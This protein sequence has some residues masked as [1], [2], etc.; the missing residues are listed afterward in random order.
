MERAPD[1]PRRLDEAAIERLV[2]E[3]DH[4]DAAFVQ[5]PY[6]VYARLREQG[7]VVHSEHYGGFYVPTR[8]ADIRAIWRDYARF[9]VQPSVN[10]PS[11]FGNSRP[12]LPLEVDP[13]LQSKYRKLL[14]PAFAP[15][16]LAVLEPRVR[17]ICV[18]LIDAFAGRRGCE[19][20]ND[21]A[22]RLPTEVFV[23]FYG[24]P[25]EE[26]DQF[27]HWKNAALHSLG[28]DPSGQT[29]LTAGGEVVARFQALLNERR[30]TARA[31][32]PDI[33]S[34]LL[35]TEIDGESLT[36]EE[37]IDISFMFFLAGLDTVQ[38]AMGMQLYFLATHPEHQR[39]IR[40][41]P[42][43]VPAAIEELLR[44]EGEVT[45]RRTAVDDV[46]VAGTTIPKGC[47]VLLVNRIANRDPAMFPDPDTVDFDRPNAGKHVAFGSGPHRCLGLGLAR[48]ELRV[49]HEELHR[50]LPEYRV[51][52]GSEI[53]MYG[54]NVAG[55]DT[56]YLEW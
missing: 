54:G 5:D 25:P 11:G 56:L 28:T 21:L 42:G 55:L 51:K 20:I 38:A 2:A 36:D 13:P 31:S 49:V 10:L 27:L 34:S 35:T 8:F 9:S 12:M 6:P 26:S 22:E 29:A 43:V 1:D 24:I 39:R 47:P 7:D 15:Q 19:V 23:Q 41:E 37:I 40:D 30:D 50:R 46:E 18:R 16:K 14:T 32:D 48:L 52:P 3:F 53:N 17:E 4:H 44:W 33:I 45:T